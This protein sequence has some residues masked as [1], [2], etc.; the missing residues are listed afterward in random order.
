[1]ATE[2][3]KVKFFVAYNEIVFQDVIFARYLLKTK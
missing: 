3:S 1:M 2:P